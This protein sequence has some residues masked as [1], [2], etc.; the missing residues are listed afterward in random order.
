MFVMFLYIVMSAA[1][2]ISA[3]IH[4]GLWIGLHAAGGSILALSAGVGIRASLKGDRT[5]KIFGGLFGVALF[6]LSLWIST[7]FSVTLFGLFLIG[8]IWAAVGFV[9]CFL[10]S[11]GKVKGNAA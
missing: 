10:F 7:G 8:P 3:G 1:L 11:G 6:T 2:A 5:Q 4:A 9:V